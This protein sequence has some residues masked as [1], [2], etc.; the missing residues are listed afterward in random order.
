MVG[1][2]RLNSFLKTAYEELKPSWLE[3]EWGRLAEELLAEELSVKIPVEIL[4]LSRSPYYRQI[5]RMKDNIMGAPDDIDAAHRDYF[6]D[7]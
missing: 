7:R 5:P 2:R 4:G 6:R 3:V 1:E